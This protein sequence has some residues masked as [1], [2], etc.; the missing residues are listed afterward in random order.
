MMTKE[1]LI[2]LNLLYKEAKPSDI[3]K[4]AFED[5]EAKFRQRLFLKDKTSQESKLI[6]QYFEEFENGDDAQKRERNFKKWKR[7]TH[8]S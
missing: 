5:I 4:K 7:E 8:N 3:I 2:E 1:K 6:G